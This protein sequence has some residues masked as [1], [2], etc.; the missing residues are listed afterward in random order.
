MTAARADSRLRGL[1]VAPHEELRGR[2]LE[3]ALEREAVECAL[4]TREGTFRAVGHSSDDAGTMTM[5]LLHGDVTGSAPI[6]VHE[7]VHCLVGDTFLSSLCRCRDSLD[8][9]IAAILRAGAGVILYA[10]VP[11]GNPLACARGQA[12][13]DPV[14]A[15]GLL[16]RAGVGEVVPV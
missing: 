12:Q 8:A 11:L 5:A 6:L 16:A 4:P 9:A 2:V 1:A 10:K 13:L 14:V 3:R 7:H 15:M